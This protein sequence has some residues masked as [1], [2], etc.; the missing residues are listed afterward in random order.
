[1]GEIIFTIVNKIDITIF[2][3]CVLPVLAVSLLIVSVMNTPK[4]TNN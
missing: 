3:L 4:N 2:V 1:M